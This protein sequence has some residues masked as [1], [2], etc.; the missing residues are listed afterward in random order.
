MNRVMVIKKKVTGKKKCVTYHNFTMSKSR[1]VGSIKGQ[2]IA[3][4]FN[5]RK[6]KSQNMTE[7]GNVK[8]INKS[9]QSIRWFPM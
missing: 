9:C 4:Y 1:V 8:K 3:D 7:E 5:F 6:K 2:N